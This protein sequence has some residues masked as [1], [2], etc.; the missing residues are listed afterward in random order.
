METQHTKLKYPRT[1]HLPWTSALT[2]DDKILNNTNHFVGKRV[3]VTEKMDGENT[4]FSKEYIHARSLDSGNH[5]SR[6]WVKNFWNQIKFDIPDNFRV[7][8]ENMYAE[9][10]IRYEDLDAYFLGF[11][12]WINE[13]CLSWDDTLYWFELLGITSVPVL[14]TGIWNEHL[15]KKLHQPGTEGYVVR[16]EESFSYS[17][18]KNSVA[19]YVRSGHVQTNKHWSKEWNPNFVKRTIM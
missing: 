17:D 1:F 3:V 8:G 15:I 19:K 11:S 18:F 9:H 4:T 12:L 7:C 13:T 6:N 14:Y 10:S 5:P 2:S 16:L